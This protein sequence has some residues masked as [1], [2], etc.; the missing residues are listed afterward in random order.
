MLQ[1]SFQAVLEVQNR[2]EFRTEVIRF[3]QNLGFRT[4]AA[5][6]VFDRSDGPAEFVTMDNTPSSYREKFE[7]VTRNHRDPVMQHCKTS[8]CPIIWDQSTYVNA[9]LAEQWEEQAPFGYHSGVAMALHLPNGRHFS[10]GVD[11]DRPLTRHQNQL[12]RM[13]ADLQLFTVYA[14]EAA[15]RIIFPTPLDDGMPHLTPREREA[16]RWTLEG[17]TAWEVGKILG[18]SERTSV[19]HV[20]NAMHKLGCVTKHQAA[21]RADRMGILR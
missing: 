17:K 8:G 4:V 3:A 16:L 14:Q 20:N 5:L 6:M 12:S 2:E 13:V 11:I 18:I 21:I 15:S 9:G 10:L 19:F 7:S 1:G